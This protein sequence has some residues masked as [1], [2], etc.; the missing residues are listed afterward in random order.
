VGELNPKEVGETLT[1][2]KKPCFDRPHRDAETHVGRWMRQPRFPR[3]GRAT[4]VVVEV[5]QYD[6]WHEASRVVVA[7]KSLQKVRLAVLA[8]NRPRRTPHVLN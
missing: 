5:N 1:I 7:V 3:R 2:R 6:P 8:V 4:L